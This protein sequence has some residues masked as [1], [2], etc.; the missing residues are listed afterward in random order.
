MT[1]TVAVLVLL[2]AGA[3]PWYGWS[4]K[5]FGQ[6]RREKLPRGKRDIIYRV[7][8]SSSPLQLVDYLAQNL[9]D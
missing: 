4:R 9:D 2:L 8:E 3:Y 5:G 7:I 6:E 1:L